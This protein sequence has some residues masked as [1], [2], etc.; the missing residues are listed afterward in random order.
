MIEIGDS[1]R[2]VNMYDFDNTIYDGES[3]VDFFLFC[4]KK[5]KNL[6]KYLPLVF[7]TALRYKLKLLSIDDLFSAASKMTSEF[8][9]NDVDFHD[10]AK[11][12]WETKKSKLKFNFINMLTENDI[13]IT[14]SP[15]FLIEQIQPLLKTRRI[16]CS[17]FDT[18][19][20][21]FEFACYRENKA[22]ALKEQYPQINVNY[23]YTDSMN[24]LFLMKF[25]K[26]SFLVKKN[27][28]IILVQET[29]ITNS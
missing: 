1:M 29:S 8:Q 13:V 22:I 4:L 14:A 27:G 28:K 10:L 21:Q 12:F 16:I 23:F 20:G 6:I 9:K 11:E 2:E 19:R 3:T 5:K 15:R 7:S 18:K 26:K 24:D 25:A 17:E